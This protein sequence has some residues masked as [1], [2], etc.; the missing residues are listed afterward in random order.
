VAATEFFF[1]LEFSSQ[2][3]PASLVEDLAEQV[4]K[5]VGCSR[6]AVTGLTEALEQAV[7][8]GAAGGHRRCD[9]QFRVANN[10]LDILV[11]SNGGRIWQKSLTIP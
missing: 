10:A 3:A 5:Y 2:G 1:A 6:D 7:A 11:S 4:F 8:A 9:V